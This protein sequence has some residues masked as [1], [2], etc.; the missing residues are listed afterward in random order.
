MFYKQRI[1]V[2]LQ[3]IIKITND[4]VAD[5]FVS[6]LTHQQRLVHDRLIKRDEITAREVEVNTIFVELRGSLEASGL[7]WQQP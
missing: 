3:V 2:R 1:F 7:P 5:S 4:H 6:L